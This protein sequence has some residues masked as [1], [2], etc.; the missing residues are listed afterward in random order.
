MSLPASRRRASPARLEPREPPLSP[1][2]HVSRTLLRMPYSISLH[3]P[4]GMINGHFR[5]APLWRG[6][7]GP[8]G[9]E[10]RRQEAQA[11]RPPRQEQPRREQP[12]QEQPQQE[13]RRQEGQR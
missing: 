5:S 6:V 4:W 3:A 10:P 13:S 11:P 9:G 8:R 2:S 1:Q 7:V 12:R